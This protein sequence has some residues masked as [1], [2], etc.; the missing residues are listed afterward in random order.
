MRAEAPWS[1][2]PVLGDGGYPSRDEFDRIRSW[3]HEHGYDRLMAYVRERWLYA[4]A[5]FWREGRDPV[6]E[7]WSYDIATG[8]WSGNEDLIE[9]LGGNIMFWMVCWHQSRRGGGYTF[10]VGTDPALGFWKGPPP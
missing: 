4:D 8:G 2:D 9:A 1:Q 7:G 10:V 5:G 3:P 6:E